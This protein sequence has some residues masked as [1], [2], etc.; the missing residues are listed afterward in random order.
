MQTIRPE[1]NNLHPLTSLG[2]VAAALIVVLHA[3]EVFGDKFV[4]PGLPL[5]QGVS[6]FFV[7]SGFILTYNYPN[8]ASRREILLFYTA[9]L[10]RI[11]PVHIASLLILIVLMCYRGQFAMPHIEWYVAVNALLLQSWIPFGPINHSFNA[12]SWSLSVEIFFYLLFPLLICNWKK[13][14][15]IK[16]TVGLLL[17][18]VFICVGN[19]YLLPSKGS[20]PWQI[21]L[22]GLL[23]IN[24]L[25]RCFE[26][27]IGIAACS[28]Y[29]E[30]HTIYLDWSWWHA[31]IVEIITVFLVPLF[32]ILSGTILKTDSIYDWIGAGGSYFLAGSGSVFIFA[33]AIFVF[34]IGRGGIS[35]I[36]SFSL[37]VRL[38]EIS[39]VLYLAHTIVLHNFATDQQIAA[40][41]LLWYLT[42]WVFCL[43][44]AYA[45]FVGI[46]QPVRVIILSLAKRY[47]GS[48]SRSTSPPSTII[49][50]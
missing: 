24:P 29:R 38:G 4:N 18:V 28:I 5:W 41:P 9:R 31:T 46:E 42:Y 14:W 7:L 23:A 1:K 25:A 32:M 43:A 21:T 35:R 44:M 40:H 2:F 30:Y 15:F 22:S 20:D 13:T 11:W 3:Q 6:F 17:I 47:I 37:A 36:L 19:Y 16:L 27:M 49:R 8:L 34:A 39:F 50:C 26:F 45:L 48:E 10:A 33:Y 12:V